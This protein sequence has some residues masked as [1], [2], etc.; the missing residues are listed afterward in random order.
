MNRKKRESFSPEYRAAV[1]DMAMHSESST[2]DLARSLGL[3]PSTVNNWVSRRKR[4]LQEQEVKPSN[5]TL[6][7]PGFSSEVYKYQVEDTGGLYKQ[8]MP[9]EV[10]TNHLVWEEGN[11]RQGRTGKYVEDEL[12]LRK[13]EEELEALRQERAQIRSALLMLINEP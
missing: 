11:I 10:F 8:E 6:S 7:A 2:S 3:N 9:K 12:W 4:Q 1:A 5:V 13:L